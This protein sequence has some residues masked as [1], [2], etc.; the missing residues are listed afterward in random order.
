MFRRL[1][2]LLL[3]GVVFLAAC[4]DDATSPEDEFTEE[5]AQFVA[6]LIDA[7]ADVVLN[8]FF[9]SSGGDPESAPA[10]THG[11]VIWTR[12]FERSRPCHDGG[13]LTIAGTGTSVWDAA[14]VTYDV[15]SS[16]TSTRA[17]CAYTNKDGVV[18][19][20]TGDGT[21][22]H[23]RHYTDYAPAGTWITTYVGGFAFTKSTGESGSCTYDLTR[24]VDTAAN[25]RTLTGKLCGNEVNRTE[26]WRNGS[27]S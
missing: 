19:E 10:L 17:S 1:T 15:D 8:D 6:D 9:N 21:W 26:T 25:T 18:I 24:T 7:T 5:D 16:G 14:A 20:L 12:T 23:E 3:S 22:T 11:P 27:A 13:T 4:G 2:W